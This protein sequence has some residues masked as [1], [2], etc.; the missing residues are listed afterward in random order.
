MWSFTYYRHLKQ[1]APHPFLPY[2]RNP[3]LSLWPQMKTNTKGS[4]GRVNTCTGCMECFD[5]NPTPDL[6]CYVEELCN[7]PH[8]SSIFL[9]MVYGAFCI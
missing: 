4:L 7:S 2:C 1:N 3:Y 8:H 9:G 5:E 6:E